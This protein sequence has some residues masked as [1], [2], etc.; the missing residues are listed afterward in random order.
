MAWAIMAMMASSFCHHRF[1]DV[2][3]INPSAYQLGAQ[4]SA[5]LSLQVFA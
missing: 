3:N 1:I 5:L 2:L 4:I